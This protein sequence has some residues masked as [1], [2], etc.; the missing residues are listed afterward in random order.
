MAKIVSKIIFFAF[1]VSINSSNFKETVIL[2]LK[3]ILSF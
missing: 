2:W 1:Y 3:F